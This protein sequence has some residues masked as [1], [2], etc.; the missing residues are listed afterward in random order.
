VR[1]SRVV[2]CDCERTAS[3][4]T[5]RYRHVGMRRR[6]QRAVVRA[7]DRELGGKRN[8]K[9]DVSTCPIQSPGPGTPAAP[10]I[11]LL[12]PVYTVHPSIHP[13]HNNQHSLHTSVVARHR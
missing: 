6:M 10:L 8:L 12:F 5:P 3:W 4:E 1:N 7:R 11:L 9:V 13:R 2:R